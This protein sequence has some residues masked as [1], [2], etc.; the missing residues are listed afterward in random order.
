[1]Y[2]LKQKH[3][4]LLQKNGKKLEMKEQKKKSKGHMK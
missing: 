4:V 2:F 3:T 1:M